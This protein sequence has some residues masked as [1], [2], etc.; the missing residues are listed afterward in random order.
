MSLLLQDSAIHDIVFKLSNFQF[1]VDDVEEL[2]SYPNL[3]PEETELLHYVLR[4]F[5]EFSRTP[6]VAE[7]NITN[8]LLNTCV[9][10]LV[11]ES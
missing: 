11:D 10:I 4:I 5:G 9:K 1:L 2:S 3:Y 6:I 8:G 7:Y